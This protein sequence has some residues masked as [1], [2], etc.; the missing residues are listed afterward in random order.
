MQVAVGGRQRLRLA[1]MTR[2]EWQ[3]V[4]ALLA[5]PARARA[6]WRLAQEAP[7]LWG[8]E[9]LL[10]IGAAALPE[11]D[12]EDFARLRALAG[13]CGEGEVPFSACTSCAATL[14]GHEDSVTSLAVTPDGSLLASGSEDNTIRL[15]HLPDG[16]CAATLRGPGLFVYSL[17]VTPDGSL[18]ASGS[19]GG[20][21]RL[22]RLPDGECV[23][24]LPGHEDRVTS[25]A[26][27]PDGSLLSS[28]SLDGT[29]LLYTSDAADE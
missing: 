20:T 4:I 16:E 3:D 10:G 17:A 2:S 25:L 23:A 13:P 27:T 5:D 12:R 8:R 9:L 15:W 11:C 21:I 7:P 18:L 14:Q 28:G 24:T 19:W 29:C 6:A 26:V 22:W 1:Q